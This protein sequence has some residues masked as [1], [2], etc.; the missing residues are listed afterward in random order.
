[1]SFHMSSRMYLYDNVFM[2][3]NRALLPCYSHLR[4]GLTSPRGSYILIITEN[5]NNNTAKA[6]SLST[7]RIPTLLSVCCN[8]CITMLAVELST[9]IVS[10]TPHQ[11]AEILSFL[12]DLLKVTMKDSRIEAVAIPRPV[13]DC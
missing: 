7:P 9:H 5:H 6:T 1:M 2:I 11:I 13:C 4:R 8:I 12:P 3:G 10:K